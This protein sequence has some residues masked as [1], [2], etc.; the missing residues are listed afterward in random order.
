MS[1]TNAARLN[2]PRILVIEDDADVAAV[3][4]LLLNQFS[5]GQYDWVA[6]SYAAMD[7]LCVKH[8]DYVIV[9]QNIPGLKGLDVLRVVDRAID[10]DPTLSD[11]TRFLKVMPVLFMSGCNIKIPSSFK[12][13]HF[14]IQDVIAK[15]SLSL[16]L[17][18]AR[19]LAS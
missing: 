15:R 16:S 1:T 6:D 10:Q 9:D 2:P 18:L 4:R 5:G 11:D 7:A 12:L 13:K 3:T 19:N 14:V 8:Y 17:S